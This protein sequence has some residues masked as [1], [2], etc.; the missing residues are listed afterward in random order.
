MAKPL[1]TG[2]DP[3]ISADE[4]EAR[5]AELHELAILDTGAE[6]EFDDLV[7][8][9]SRIAGKP[10]ALMSL[11]DEDRQWFKARKGLEATETPRDVAFC[12]RAIQSPGEPLIVED[13]RNDPRFSDNPL[14]TGDPHVAFYAGMPIVTS[15]GHALGTICVIDRE[16][17]E[18]TDDQV[19]ALKG[20][21]RQAA[22]LLELRRRTRNLTSV[23]DQ[24]RASRGEIPSHDRLTGLPDRELLERAIASR[25]PNEPAGLMI[26]DLLR[27]SE[28]NAALGREG[29]DAVLQAVAR[30]VAD[31]LNATDTLARVDGTTFAAFLPRMRPAPTAALARDLSDLLARPIEVD[32]QEPIKVSAAIGTATDSGAA[33]GD[34][35]ALLESAEMATAQAKR[36]GPGAT[37]TAGSETLGERARRANLRTALSKAIAEGAVAVVYMPVVELAS[38]AVVGAEA[39]ARFPG[40]EFK[41]S[42]VEE[43]IQLAEE[44]GMVGDIDELVVDR[45]LADFAAGRIDSPSVGANI[46]PVA[47]GRDLPDRI[48]AA[49]DRH[50]VRP[51][52]FVIEITERV[53]LSENPDLKEALTELSEMGIRIGI[54]DFGAGATA[55]ADLRNLPFDAI[56][57]DRGLIT[58]IDGPDGRRALMVVQ[59]L[60]GMAKGLGI[61]VLGEGVET[62]SQREK[63]LEVG[64]TF[65]QGYLFGRPAPAGEVG[66]PRDPSELGAP[67]P[68]GAQMERLA[69][70]FFDQ[71]PDMACVGTREQL[72]RVNENWERV[73]GW[74]EEEMLSRPLI[75]LIHPDDL[76]R[77][78][79]RLD[80]LAEGEP[81]SSFEARMLTPEGDWRILDWNARRDGDTGLNLATARDVTRERTAEMER[82]RL[83][84]V[85]EVLSEL[86][87][88]Y[89][90][91]GVSRQWWH[92]ALDRIIDLTDSEYGFIGRVEHDEEGQPYLISYAL[93]NIAWNDW[94]RGVFEE[95]KDGGLEFHNLQTLFG[96]TLSTGEMV[97]ANDA[98]HDSRRGGLPEGHP[99]LNHYAGIPFNSDDGIVGMAGLANR[100][101]GYSEEL[102]AELQPIFASLS[103]IISRDIANRRARQVEFDAGSTT[104]AVEAIL[105]SQDIEQAMEIA[106]QALKAVEPDT[107]AELFVIGD[108][109]ER[110]GRVGVENPHGDEVLHREACLALTRGEPHVSRPSDPADQRCAHAGPESV[111][112][113]VPVDNPDEEF[114]LII[115]ESGS[116]PET[117]ELSGEKVVRLEQTLETLAAAV[118]EVARR[119]DLTHRA[120]T[121][122]LTGLANRPAFVQKVNRALDSSAAG[123][124]CFGVMML[125]LDNFKAVNDSLGHQAGDMLLEEAGAK[126]K[127]ALRDEDTVARLGGDEF[128][129]IVR[130]CGTSPD[131]LRQTCE[132][133]RETISGIP[134]ED[135]L[136]VTA[137]IGAVE[138]DGPHTSWDEIYRI[139]DR[140]LYASKKEGRD[141]VHIAAD[142][143]GT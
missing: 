28:V 30:T 55:I 140:E 114:G 69:G 136:S 23:L 99:A 72:L 41:G 128:G 126:I 76:P 15:D 115:V 40:S 116:G 134:V 104:A 74:S 17:G 51:D 70:T 61:D 109:R 103:Q 123:G 4:E 11:L 89:I 65:G 27:F 29:G 78:L 62:E 80:A 8:T 24:E 131:L 85:M 5:L 22:A 39:L 52:C 87:E 90:E 143:L 86:Q 125:D 79:E 106:E 75:E 121:D 94:S 102:I 10:I 38:G 93:T 14:V 9:A 67:R 59:A 1:D 32:G 63:L 53:A 92:D 34:P 12:N 44:E 60:T 110:L 96:V 49:L 133:V 84:L 91:Q 127:G 137:S 16:P 57:L 132:R 50:G 117:G 19:E 66:I 45:A 88:E 77:T 122:S 71:T 135:G 108:S 130:G 100:P 141:E 58:D 124:P 46:S 42:S 139:A 68:V 98:P 21:S 37:V 35:A 113:C 31:R 129:V 119:Q 83:R 6:P 82:D 107:H 43:I 47:I 112:I 105:D 7:E 64:V 73:M 25:D 2:G 36:K 18:L 97:I 56:K 120:L 20:I 54:D 26:I 3:G 118:A 13:A 111:T 138:V 48:R 81:T 33:G 95:F 101:G 142:R